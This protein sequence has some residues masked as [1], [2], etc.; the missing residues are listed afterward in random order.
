[1]RSVPG[2]TDML[3]MRHVSCENPLAGSHTSVLLA[4]SD[5]RCKIPYLNVYV[6]KKKQTHRDVLTA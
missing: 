4:E 5:M 2:A 3:E 6:L 1:M